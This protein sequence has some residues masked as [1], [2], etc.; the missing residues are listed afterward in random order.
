M[1]REDPQFSMPADV[2]NLSF[3][4]DRKFEA[5]I[6]SRD[7]DIRLSEMPC[8]NDSGTPIIC[9]NN[10]IFSESPNPG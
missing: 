5:I 6:P 1:K 7:E 8:G 3:N 4:F 2:I 9:S 10:K